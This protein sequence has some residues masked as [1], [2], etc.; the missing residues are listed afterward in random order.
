M[1]TATRTILDSPAILSIKCRIKSAATKEERDT[2][3]TELQRV[4]AFEALVVKHGSEDAAR[5]IIAS[6][7]DER[8]ASRKRELASIFG[9]NPV[10]AHLFPNPNTIFHHRTSQE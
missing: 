4:R 10:R 3:F 9:Q 1:I 8:I 5:R 7:E 6:I 2:L